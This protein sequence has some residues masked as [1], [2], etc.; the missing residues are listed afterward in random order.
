MGS[1]RVFRI[2]RSL[3]FLFI[4]FEDRFVLYRLYLALDESAVNEFH[5]TY[6][7]GI[8][9]KAALHQILNEAAKLNENTSK[10]E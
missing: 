10:V 8:D 5:H 4:S 9:R 2:W 7:S 3:F 6:F 1:L